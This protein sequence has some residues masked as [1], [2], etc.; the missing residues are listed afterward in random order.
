LLLA[1]LVEELLDLG[2]A[3][4]RVVIDLQFLAKCLVVEQAQ[5]HPCR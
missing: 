3:G 2:A 5:N 1:A 4:A